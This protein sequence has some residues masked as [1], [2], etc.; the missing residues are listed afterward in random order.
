VTESGRFCLPRSFHATPGIAGAR[1]LDIYQHFAHGAAAESDKDRPPRHAQCFNALPAKRSAPW[2]TILHQPYPCPSCLAPPNLA[3]PDR[4]PIPWHTV[5][6][7]AP[8]NQTAQLI[9]GTPLRPPA[10]LLA[11]GITC[12]AAL[13]SC[14]CACLFTTVLRQFQFVADGWGTGFNDSC[15]RLGH[16]IGPLGFVWVDRSE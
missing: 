10:C 15:H 1:T 6:P 4:A 14:T 8:A 5:C 3:L 7:H 12:P 2:P 11:R 16:S 9:T 13:A